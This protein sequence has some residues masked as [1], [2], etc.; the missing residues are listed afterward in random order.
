MSL[1]AAEIYAALK[2]YMRN[3]L[4]FSPPTLNSVHVWSQVF[5][6]FIISEISRLQIEC[7]LDWLL[8]LNT[9]PFQYFIMKIFKITANLKI[10]S[11]DLTFYFLLYF[12]ILYYTSFGIIL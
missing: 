9:F 4:S 7:H 3:K 2:E 11:I 6:L 1:P 8:L 10:E 12:D 5:I